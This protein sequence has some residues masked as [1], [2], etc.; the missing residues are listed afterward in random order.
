MAKIQATMSTEIALDMLQASDSI[1]RITQ[2]VN[3]ATNAWKAQESQLRAT[4]DYLGA[5]QAK[6]DGLDNAIQQQAKI[7]KLRKE[8]SELKGNTVETAEQY[9]KYQQQIDQATAKLASMESQQQKAKSSVYYYK[10]G[11]AGLQQQFKQQNEVSETYIKRLQAEGKESEANEEKAK[12]L[13]GS[14]ENLTKQYKTQEDMLQKIAAESGKTSS[15]YLLQK[16]RL[17]ETAT[18]LANAKA[19]ANRFNAG[20]ICNNSSNNKTKLLE[21]TSNGCRLKEERAK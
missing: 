12:H 16:K 10:S 6:Y 5:A 15:E 19:N 3:H 7:E 2:L 8:Q 18:S 21:H 4:G 1:K 11:L 13:K 20:L 14:I 17:D 9:L